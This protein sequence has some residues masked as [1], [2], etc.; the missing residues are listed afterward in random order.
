MKLFLVSLFAGAFASI[1]LRQMQALNAIFDAMGANVRRP[2]ALQLTV[3]SQGCPEMACPRLDF[4]E[5]CM[6]TLQLVLECDS[7]TGITNLCVGTGV[8][9][10]KSENASA[11]V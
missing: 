9:E 8:F 11:G 10:K 4:G 3:S 5:I 7:A 2:L 6:N 1:P